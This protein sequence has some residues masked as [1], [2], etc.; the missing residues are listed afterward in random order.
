MDGT[1]IADDDREC[2]YTLNHCSVK[3]D[4]NVLSYAKF[5]QMAQKVKALL[6]LLD[7]GNH[8]DFPSQIIGDDGTPKSKVVDLLNGLAVESE[9]LKRLFIINPH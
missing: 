6:G 3:L 8:I 5:L 9:R 4:Q 2:Q 1:G 7:S